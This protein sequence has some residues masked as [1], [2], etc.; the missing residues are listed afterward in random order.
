MATQIVTLT[1][2]QSG[3]T[4]KILASLG[5]N[6]YQFLVPDASGPIDLLWAEQGFEEGTK[7]ASGSGIPLLFPFPGRI[8]GTS[9]LWDGKQY[10]LEAG[11]GL[12]NAIHGFVHERPWRIIEQEQSRVVAQFQASVDDP[13]Y[14]IAGRPIFGSRPLMKSAIAAS[15]PAFNCRTPTPTLYPVVS[16]R[17][18]ISVSLWEANPHSSAR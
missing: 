9:L 3:A 1:D 14:W 8:A 10:P 17:T 16:A 11:D 12:G 7:R 13:R 15:Q 18:R 6:C 5:M 2:S 4:A